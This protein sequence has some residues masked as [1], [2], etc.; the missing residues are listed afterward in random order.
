[1]LI[2]EVGYGD[3]GGLGM[4]EAAAP[5]SAEPQLNLRSSSRNKWGPATFTPPAAPQP[6]ATTAASVPSGYPSRCL[7]LELLDLSS[8]RKQ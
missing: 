8:T 2:A 4:G 5:S 1:M 6:T 3:F 7:V